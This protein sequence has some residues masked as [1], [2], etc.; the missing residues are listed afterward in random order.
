MRRL[1]A[2][3]AVMREEGATPERS[4]SNRAWRESRGSRSYAQQR[5]GE[6]GGVKSAPAE[7]AAAFRP[8]RLRPGGRARQTENQH[9][10]AASVVRRRSYRSPLRPLFRIQALRRHRRR[11]QTNRS[12]KFRRDKPVNQAL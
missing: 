1:P 9:A 8:P 3:D 5:P 4:A 6:R 11:Q 2:A 7:A 12:L 10:R